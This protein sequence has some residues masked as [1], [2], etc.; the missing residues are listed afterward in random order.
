MIPID[1]G[2][3]KWNSTDRKSIQWVQI[4]CFTLENAHLFNDNEAP[5]RLSVCSNHVWCHG[6]GKAYQVWQSNDLEASLSHSLLSNLKRLYDSHIGYC[7]SMGNT[8]YTKFETA[9]EIGEKLHGW[10]PTG[11]EVCLFPFPWCYV[12]LLTVNKERCNEWTG[13]RKYHLWLVDGRSRR[14]LRTKEVFGGEKLVPA[15]W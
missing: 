6:W 12:W 2:L 3:R 1:G 9:A 14:D 15:I 7:D 10:A 5:F 11:G 4:I 8:A 13:H